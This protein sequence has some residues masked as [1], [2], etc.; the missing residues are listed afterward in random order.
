MNKTEKPDRYWLIGWVIFCV[1]FFFFFGFATSGMFFVSDAGLKAS[2]FTDVPCGKGLQDAFVEKDLDKESFDFLKQFLDL[3]ASKLEEHR[4][5]LMD[6]VR[7]GPD[8]YRFYIAQI[9]EQYYPD[10]DPYIALAVLEIESDYQPNVQS[11]CGAVGLMQWI[12]KWHSWRMEKFHLNDMWD[13]YTNIIVGMDFLN[14]LYSS[15]GSWEKALYGY[16]N[17]TSYVRSVLS[18]ADTLREGGLFG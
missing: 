12:P 16:N 5:K 1:A 6:E 15:A 11:N 4:L 14:D 18:R 7:S 13:P 10:V 3:S 9:N 17:S 2:E 8:L